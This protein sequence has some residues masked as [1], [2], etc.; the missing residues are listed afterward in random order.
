MEREEEEEDY[1]LTTVVEGEHVEEEGRLEGLR[2][3]SNHRHRS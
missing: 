1:Q 3:S 2:G